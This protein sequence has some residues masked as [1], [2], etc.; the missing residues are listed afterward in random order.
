[1]EDNPKVVWRLM[2]KY[3]LQKN[4][5]MQMPT[6]SGAGAG[7]SAE[8][9]KLLKEGFEKRLLEVQKQS[10]ENMKRISAESELEITRLRKELDEKNEEY[11]MLEKQSLADMEKAR[12]EIEALVEAKYAD[13]HAAKFK[14][15]DLEK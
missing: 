6:I 2:T 5:R 3:Y 9:V 10:S 13:I 11:A 12:E 14:K 4:P 7:A 1:M 8:H 15:L